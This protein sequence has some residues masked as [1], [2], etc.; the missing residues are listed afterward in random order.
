MKIKLR[1]ATIQDRTLLEN[2]D[3]QS[4]VIA[5]DP[6]DDWNWEEELLRKPDWREQLIAELDGT[7]VGFIQ[8]IDPGRED[9]HYWGNITG[10]LRALD[11]WI[12]DEKNLG[13]GYGTIMMNMAL[14]I[15][16]KDPLVEAVLVDP[17]VSNYRAHQFYEGQGFKFVVERY[18]G[19]DHCRVY[20]LDR[21]NF[22]NSMMISK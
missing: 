3:Q 22:N 14:E 11:I 13:K 15:C 10:H 17:L 5:S 8:I 6:N 21:A 12:G 4:H 20:R 18:F 9:T 19:S 2:W 16:F 1:E 7:P